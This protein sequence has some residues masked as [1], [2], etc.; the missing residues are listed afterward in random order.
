MMTFDSG[1]RFVLLVVQ[2][3]LYEVFFFISVC[4]CV[5]LILLVL[6]SLNI[7]SF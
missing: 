3:V 4:V 6:F 5:V 1:F 2:L 7:I